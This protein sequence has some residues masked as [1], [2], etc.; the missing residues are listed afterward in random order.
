MNSIFVQLNPDIQLT[1]RQFQQLCQNNRNLNFERSSQGDLII[2]SPTG[3][4]TGNRNGRLNQ[5]LFN[6]S[7]RDCSGIAFDSSTGFKLPNGADRSPDAAWVTNDR[8]N[9]LTVDEQ[10]RFI[11]LCPDFVVELM[12]PSDSRSVLQSKMKE[13]QDNGVRLGI[14]IDRTIKQIEIY[15]IGKTM[16]IVDRPEIIS[17]E[18][19]L[20][21]FELQ[22]SL[23]W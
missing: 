10:D 18:D 4:S 16:E 22:M 6:W 17:G 5:Q 23:I 20:P 12:S 9:A 2:M 11:P 15:R 3:G 13:Y 21:G 1:D 14:L 7:D 8:W 19:V